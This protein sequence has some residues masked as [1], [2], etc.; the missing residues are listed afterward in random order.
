MD[1]GRFAW[2]IAVWM[3]A[4][5]AGLAQDPRALILESAGRY[6]ADQELERNYTYRER[7]QERNYDGSG[8]VKSTEIK[9]YDVISLYGRPYHRL[10]EKDGKPLPPKEEAAEQ[11][12]IDKELDKRSR[13]PESDRRSRLAKEAKEF[14]QE[15]TFRKEMADAF[16]FKLLAEESVSGLACYVIQADPKPGYRPRTRQGNVLVKVKGKLWISKRDK[17]WVKVEAETIDTFSLGWFLL[18]VAKGTRIAFEAERVGGEVWM[19]SHAFIRGE[20]RVAAVKKFNLELDVRWSDF[21]KFST[22]SRIV[23]SPSQ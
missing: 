6:A 15:R 18:R 5:V 12:K 17:R 14:E 11:R 1:V 3:A 23:A 19:P 21:R 20:A 13:E 22:D 2:T 9:V 16:V 8:K 10:I 4:S 7:T